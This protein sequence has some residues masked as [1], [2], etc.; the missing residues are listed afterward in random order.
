[1]IKSTQGIAGGAKRMGDPH[2]QPITKK[3]VN[4]KDKNEKLNEILE[5]EAS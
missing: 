3:Q 2:G 5:T 4:N 1:M